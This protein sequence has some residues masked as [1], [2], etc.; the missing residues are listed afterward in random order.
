MSQKVF[1][2]NSRIRDL[3]QQYKTVCKNYSGAGQFSDL[4][5]HMLY[6]K[7]LADIDKDIDLCI[8]ECPELMPDNL[9]FKR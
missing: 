8:V 9:P 6:R 3:I 4:K 7:Q 2:Y 1:A 5:D